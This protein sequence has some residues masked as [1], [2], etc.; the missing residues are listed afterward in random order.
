MTMAE[1]KDTR[2]HGGRVHVE[3]ILADESKSNFKNVDL[4]TLTKPATSTM[5]RADGR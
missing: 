4:Q 2:E 5:R 3:Q 1:A